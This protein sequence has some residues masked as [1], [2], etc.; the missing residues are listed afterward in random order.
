RVQQKSG[1]ADLD[2]LRGLADLNG[3]I[4]VSHLRDL[5][6]NAHPALRTESVRLDLDGVLSGPQVTDLIAAV[7]R[8]EDGSGQPG[9]RLSD[10]HQGFRNHG[11]TLV[12]YRAQNSSVD[13]L[14]A[15]QRRSQ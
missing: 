7:V 14:G 5:Q 13:R 3:E 12:G 2:P 9:C 10:S 1:S 15:K 4:D 11:P 6:Q 8:S